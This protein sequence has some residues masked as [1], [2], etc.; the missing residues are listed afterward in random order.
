MIAADPRLLYWKAILI[1]G[2]DL[3]IIEA[4]WDNIAKAIPAK[5]EDWTKILRAD[6]NTRFGDAPTVHIG[7]LQPEVSNPKSEP[8]VRF[9][10]QQ[11]T[12]ICSYQQVF[13]SIMKD[14]QVLGNIAMANG[15]DMMLLPFHAISL[16]GTANLG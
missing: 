4:F 8:F 9:V 16:Y 12:K 6:A 5:Y 2:A 7:D 1:V 3:D 14:L 11:E 13:Q 15:N 10:C